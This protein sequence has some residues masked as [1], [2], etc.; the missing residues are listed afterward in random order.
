[1]RKF[2]L[3]DLH[4]SYKALKQV[5]N[6]VNFD[7]ENDKL[8]FLG[9]LMDSYSEPDKCTEELMNIKNFVFIRGNHDQ[10]GIDFYEGKM[11][12]RISSDF[13]SWQAHGGRATYECYGETMPKEHL[14]FLKSSVFYHEEDDCLF[15]HGGIDPNYDISKQYPEIFMWDRSLVQ[16]AYENQLKKTVC[17][18]YK[19]IFVGHTPLQSFNSKKF[20]PNKPQR[21]ANVNLLDTGCAFNGVL[22]LMNLEDRTYVNSD[23]SMLLYPDERGRNRSSYNEIQEFLKNNKTNL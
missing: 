12:K 10:W 16:R 8:I 9:D 4:S 6:K 5:L 23:P 22:T 20:D 15:V 14:D 7:Y 3:G 21:W 17:E 1:M 19:D 18:K 13:A 2:I 11:K